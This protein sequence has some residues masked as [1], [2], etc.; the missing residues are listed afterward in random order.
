MFKKRKDRENS[1]LNIFRLTKWA[2]KAFLISPLILLGKKPETKKDKF[3]RT[4]N[5]IFK[6]WPT[7]YWKKP[8]VL[9]ASKWIWDFIKFIFYWK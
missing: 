3:F 2:I 5:F 1:I 8:S 9:K 4:M 7:Y 6:V